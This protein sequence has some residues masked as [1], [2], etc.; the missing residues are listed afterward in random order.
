MPTANPQGSLGILHHLRPAS[1]M[2]SIIS[3]KFR[4]IFSAAIDTSEWKHGIINSKHNGHLSMDE[5]FKRS[6]WSAYE[7]K[8]TE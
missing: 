1:D 5:V 6:Y 8:S 3:T 7:E 2:G 4:R